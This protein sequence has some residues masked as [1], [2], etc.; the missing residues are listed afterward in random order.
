MRVDFNSIYRVKIFVERFKYKFRLSTIHFL[1][2]DI[3]SKGVQPD[4]NKVKS[5]M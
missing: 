5:I 4:S 1:G 2:Y 3:S